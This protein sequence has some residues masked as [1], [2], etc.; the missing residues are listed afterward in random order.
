MTKSSVYNTLVEESN[1]D[2]L[3]YNARTGALARF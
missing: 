1:G 3:L 2:T